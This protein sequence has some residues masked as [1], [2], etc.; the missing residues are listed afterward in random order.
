MNINCKKYQVFFGRFT[1]EVQ[2]QGNILGD[3]WMAKYR[4]NHICAGKNN[5]SNKKILILKSRH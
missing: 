3:D 4:I 1:L 5:V 2:L